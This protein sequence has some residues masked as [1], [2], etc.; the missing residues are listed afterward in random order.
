MEGELQ[1]S[2]VTEPVVSR[3]LLWLASA[4]LLLHLAVNAFHSYGIFRDEF[5]Y[6][7]CAKHLSFG[8]VDQPPLSIL[9]LALQTLF[10]GDSLFAIRILPA[11]AGAATVFLAG[12]LAREL[13]GGKFAQITAALTVLLVPAYLTLS[14]F[15]SMNAFDLLCWTLA[16]YILIK[17]IKAPGPR[18]WIVMGAVLGLGILNKLSVLFLILGMVVG[19][20]LSRHRRLLKSKYVWLT[21]LITLV[22][23]AP[24]GIWEIAN[25]WPT[26]EFIAN[27]QADIANLSVLAFFES[28]VVSLNPIFSLLWLSGLAWLL[29][30]RREK[31]FRAI[32][33]MYIVLFI[34]LAVQRTK[35]YYLFVVYPVLFAAG[36]VFWERATERRRW[37]RAVVLPVLLCA[38]L[39]TLPFGLPILSPQAMASYNSVLRK[40]VEASPNV[41]DEPAPLPKYYADRFGWE[42]FAAAVSDVYLSLPESDRRETVAF[43]GNY[44][45]AGALDYYRGKYPLPPVISGHNAYWFWGP[46]EATGEVVIH[47]GGRKDQYEQ[48]YA[49]STLMRTFHC[50][51]CLPDNDGLGIFVSR[52]RRAPLSADWAQAKHFD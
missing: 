23:S 41:D 5:Y 48:F 7:A 2:D 46:G 8:Y 31:R 29:F 49:T 12:L 30:S 51:Y 35:P 19:L 26:L 42:Q 22:I 45:Q 17:L 34:F 50:T 16:I 39:L 37:T 1:T 33:F 15:Y 14:G 4:G 3:L 38:G 40:P 25:G 43:L 21:A 32:G 20:L 13:G 18:L 11:V 28:Q 52:Q 6:L 44:G 10:I 24:Y 47:V 27:S 36:A 9:L